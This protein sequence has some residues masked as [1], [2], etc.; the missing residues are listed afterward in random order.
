MSAAL[1]FF[2]H[3]PYAEV[4][5]LVKLAT[6]CERVVVFDHTLRESDSTA[7]LNAGTAAVSA[8]PVNR[9]HCDYTE[10]SGPKRVAEVLSDEFLRGRRFAIVNVWRSVPGKVVFYYCE[11]I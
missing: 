2:R 5:A 10:N 11:T 1:L 8:A 9:V 4:E 6:G 7:G 3:V